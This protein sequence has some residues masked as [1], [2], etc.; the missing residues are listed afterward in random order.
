MQPGLVAMVL[1]GLGGSMGRVGRRENVDLGLEESFS[2]GASQAVAARCWLKLLSSEGSSG[3]HI[4]R[5]V[6]TRLA[7]DAGSRL[8]SQLGLP[9]NW[10]ITEVTCTW[11]G[12]H[13][14][15]TS[16]SEAPFQTKVAKQQVCLFHPFLSPGASTTDGEAWIPE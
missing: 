5:A 7:A 15:L 9:A 13:P 2:V 12:M 14:A 10:N 6:C 3:L 8:G 11:W 4:P 16:G 1:P